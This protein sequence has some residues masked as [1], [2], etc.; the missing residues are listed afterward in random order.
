METPCDWE[1]TQACCPNWDSYDPAIQTAATNYA[2]MIAWARTGRRFGLCPKVVRP[3]GRWRPNWPSIAGF[4]Y[5]AFNG[6]W[7]PFIDAGG[8]WR[9][10]M[11]PDM[12]CICRP[13]CEAWLPGPVNSITT[14]NLNGAVIDP[15]AYRVDDGQ[16]LVRTDGDCW[17]DCADYN[18]NTGEGFFQVTYVRGIP[19][20]AVLAEAAGK[21]ACEFAKACVGDNTCRLPG[22]LRSLTRSGVEVAFVDVDTLLK[23]GLTGIIEVDQVFMAMN[24]KNLFRP[25]HVWSPDMPRIRTVTSP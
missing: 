4:E 12:C 24:P 13:E 19:V 25:S 11:C 9:N 2:T 23:N 3:C 15:S 1:I 21:L 16:W 18:V 6:T 20:P 10:C 17:P 5:S 14:V 8:N 22:R 7:I